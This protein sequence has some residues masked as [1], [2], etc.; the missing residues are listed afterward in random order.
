MYSTSGNGQDLSYQIYFLLAGSAV[1]STA[2]Q[3]KT[4]IYVTHYLFIQLADYGRPF[5]INTAH[6]WGGRERTSD[7]QLL[8]IRVLIC[9]SFA[10]QAYLKKSNKLNRN[11]EQS[12]KNSKRITS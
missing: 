1:L 4:I 2:P 10:T 6:V 5:S 3:Q 12:F 11:C 9:A 8:P 7:P